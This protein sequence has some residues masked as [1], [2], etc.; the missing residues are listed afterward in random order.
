MF[1]YKCGTRIPDGGKFCPACGTAAQG[2]TAA[3]QP[4]PQTVEPFPQPSPITQATS[5]GAMPFEDYRSLLEGR[6][7]IGQFVPELNAWMYYSEEFRIKWGASKMKKYVFL[8][9]F[10]KLDAQAL[11]TYS[12]A[13]IKHA[14]KI[15]QGLPRG[16]QTGVG[17]FAIAASNVVGQDAVD[18]ALQ[19]PPKHY[20]AFELPVIADLQNRRICHM[21]RTP[22]WG[23]LLWKD[24]RNFATA[25]AKF[26]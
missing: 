18:L 9:A 25:C 11:R 7:G 6:L 3:S 1:C 14:L 15:Y 24:I 22:M 20:A 16:F 17:S 26:E 21:Q 2:S 4:A 8:S 5:N 23:A 12:D 19:I 10:E 13:C